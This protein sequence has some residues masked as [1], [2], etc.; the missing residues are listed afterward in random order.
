MYKHNLHVMD[1][2]LGELLG[3]GVCVCV[4]RRTAR[5]ALPNWCSFLSL[6]ESSR[7]LRRVVVLQVLGSFMAVMAAVMASSKVPP[8]RRTW[9]PVRFSCNS[10][11]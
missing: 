4:A 5:V 7:Y 3:V 2:R 1:G 8:L 6:L 9:F 11:I 10:Q